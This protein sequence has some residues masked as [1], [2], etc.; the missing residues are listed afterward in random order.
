MSTK[1]EEKKFWITGVKPPTKENQPYIFSLFDEDMKTRLPDGKTWDKSLGEEIA[2]RLETKE[3]ILCKATIR[4]E[5][6]NGY[7][8]YRL[9]SVVFLQEKEKQKGMSIY[10]KIAKE[11]LEVT[12]RLLSENKEK[13]EELGVDMTEVFRV[14]YGTMAVQRNKETMMRRLRE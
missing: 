8:Y 7:T 10:H 9:L 12:I 14:V 3:A 4:E 11:N 6:F 1:T 13:L 2:E 5:A